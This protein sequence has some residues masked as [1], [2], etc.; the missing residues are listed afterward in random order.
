MAAWKR[1]PDEEGGHRPQQLGD[2]TSVD[3]SVLQLPLLHDAALADNV[4]V[5]CRPVQA[6]ISL[7]PYFPGSAGDLGNIDLPASVS[8]HCCTPGPSGNLS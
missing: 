5:R 6:P 2:T 7:R 3:E 1:F 4:S 8:A